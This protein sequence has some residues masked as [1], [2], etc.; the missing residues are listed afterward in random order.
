MST[1]APEITKT[2][3][4]WTF[5]PAHSQVSFAVKHMMV[6]TVRGQFTGV[7]GT[8]IGEVH[9]PLGAEIDVEIDANS[10][11]T[12]NEQRDAHLRSADFLDAE[13]YPTLTFKS[14][15]IEEAG[16]DRYTIHGD[17]TIRGTTREVT[18][19]AE[20]NGHGT[21]PWGTEVV[22]VSARGEINRKEFGLNWNVAL[23]TG[24]ILVGETIKIDIEVEAIK[25][26]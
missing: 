13:N 16:K 22:G 7:S 9:E 26:A 6:S 21:S 18:L 24:G 14:T 12:N 23:E 1:I 2:G 20:L 4:V 3:T 5:D 15:H 10:I 8:T 17:L 25:Q 19:E 11:T